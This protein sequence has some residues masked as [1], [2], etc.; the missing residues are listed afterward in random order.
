MASAPI[1]GAEFRKPNPQA[2]VI[3]M[4]RAYMGRSA[5]APPRSTAA[6]SRD[7]AP[8]IIGCLRINV[9][10]ANRDWILAGSRLEDA[11]RVRMK[12]RNVEAVKNNIPVTL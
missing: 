9:I 10:P 7:K 3:R 11:C 6:R 4:S 5:V 8:R 12:R 2:P 1:E